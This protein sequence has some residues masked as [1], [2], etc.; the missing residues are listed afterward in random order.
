M[1]LQIRLWKD[2]LVASASRRDL[3]VRS[4]AQRLTI[5]PDS[6]GMTSMPLRMGTTGVPLPFAHHARLTYKPEHIRSKRS[7]FAAQLLLDL[8]PGILER[9]RAVEDQSFGRGI[10]IEAE[11]TQ[12]LKLVP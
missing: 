6:A 5:H 3:L 11:I 10:R 8:R 7:T 1:P 12:T 4:A 9:N 2:A